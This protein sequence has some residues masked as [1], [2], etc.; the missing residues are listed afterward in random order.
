MRKKLSLLFLAIAVLMCATEYASAQSKTK[1]INVIPENADIFLNGESVGV[2]TYQTDSK[3]GKDGE[4]FTIKSAGYITQ[5]IKLFQN[6]PSETNIDLLVDEAMKMSCDSIRGI[7]VNKYF[8]VVCGEDVYESLAWDRIMNIVNSTFKGMV[9]GDKLAGWIETD[10][11]YTYYHYQAVRTRI[12]FQFQFTD[13]CELSCR[14][15]F[16]SEINN[17]W[18]GVND[19]FLG[20]YE[21]YERIL[22]KYGELIDELV[23]SLEGSIERR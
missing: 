9:K 15:T 16:Y 11:E 14:I 17:A 22:Y 23:N 3:I 6:S 12:S 18:G 7:V 8:N 20:N 1:T 19:M 4:E 5:T 2:G 13:I 10:W 21:K